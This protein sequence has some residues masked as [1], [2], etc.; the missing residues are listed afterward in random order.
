MNPTINASVIARLIYSWVPANAKTPM[1]V[2]INIGSM[3]TGPTDKCLD[4]PNK[5]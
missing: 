1:P 4:V 2:A 5:A 3:A